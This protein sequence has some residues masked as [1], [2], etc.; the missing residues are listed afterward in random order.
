VQPPGRP[1]AAFAAAA[2]FRQ[3]HHRAVAARLQTARFEAPERGH[4]GTGLLQKQ[5]TGPAHLDT[6]G[7]QGPLQYSQAAPGAHHR[8]FRAERRRRHR[9]Q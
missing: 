7:E 3:G 2:H 4:L 8:N 1:V 9:P 6:V 5:P